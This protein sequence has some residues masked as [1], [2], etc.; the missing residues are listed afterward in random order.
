MNKAKVATTLERETL[1]VLEQLVAEQRFQ[2]RSEAIEVAV[3]QKRRW[4]AQQ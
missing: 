4:L 1:V 2:W 3:Q